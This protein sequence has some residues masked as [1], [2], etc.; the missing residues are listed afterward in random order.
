MNCGLPGGIHLVP[1]LDDVTHDDTADLGSIKLGAFERLAHHR[2]TEIAGRNGL[3]RTVES[4]YCG[5][6]RLAKYDFA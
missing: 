4:S 3:E 6:H 2:C 1:G 5:A